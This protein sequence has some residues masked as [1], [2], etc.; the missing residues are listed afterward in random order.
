MDFEHARCSCGNELRHTSCQIFYGC[1]G[2]I[3]QG[4]SR[5]CHNPIWAAQAAGQGVRGVINEV[6]RDVRINDL[7]VLNNLRF[8]VGDHQSKPAVAVDARNSM[9]YWQCVVYAAGGLGVG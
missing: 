6:A 7:V 2:Q 8:A 9:V 4:P 5:A 3:L 1:E